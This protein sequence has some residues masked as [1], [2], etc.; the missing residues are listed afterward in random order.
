MPSF[1]SNFVSAVSV[2]SE[3]RTSTLS[4]ADFVRG[5]RSCFSLTVWTR[6]ELLCQMLFTFALIGLFP[7]SI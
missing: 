6:I 2:Q 5:H 1:R 3:W 7:L 4:V